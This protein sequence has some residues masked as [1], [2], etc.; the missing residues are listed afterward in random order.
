M[1]L[2]YHEKLNIVYLLIFFSDKYLREKRN[3]LKIINRKEKDEN[4][5]L[6][7]CGL[8]DEVIEQDNS[9]GS[10]DIEQKPK[11]STSLKGH[12]SK[13]RERTGVWFK[14]KFK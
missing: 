9:R 12:E 11:N 4:L 14:E 13:I 5:S 6:N 2:F 3:Y 8:R 7:A 1:S 10:Q